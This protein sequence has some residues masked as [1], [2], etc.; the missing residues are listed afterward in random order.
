MLCAREYVKTPAVDVVRPSNG[1]VFEGSSRTR[2]PPV[3]DSPDGCRLACLGQDSL[4]AQ[5]LAT[6]GADQSTAQVFFDLKI[7][8]CV[9][10]LVERR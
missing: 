8:E 4:V 5:I 2:L 1:V 3:V 9:D 6:H 10:H 7:G